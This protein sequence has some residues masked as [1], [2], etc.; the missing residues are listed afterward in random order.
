MRPSEPARLNL[1]LENAQLR[2]Q[3]AALTD[4]LLRLEARHRALMA[5]PSQI[6]WVTSPDGTL[7]ESPAWLAY[8]GLSLE[9]CRN[10]GWTLA[11]HPDDRDRV[12]QRWQHALGT[13]GWFGADF[14]LRRHDGTYR[15]FAARGCP[16]LDEAGD[17]LEWL[18]R[19]RDIE[20]ERRAAEALQQQATRIEAEVAER[21]H[22]LRKSE[23]MLAE[24]Q[25]LA[26][27]G[28]W[29]L[30]IATRQL[31]WSQQQFRN[32]G[33]EPT[34]STVDRALAV[35]RIDPRDVERH[36]AVVRQAIEQ[37]TAF[38]MD[39]RVVQPDG[40]VLNIHS[41]G[42]PVH[43][44]A[45][46]LI[47]FVGTSQDVTERSRLE[48]Q[49]RAQYEQLK[50][51]DCLKNNIVNSV[52]HELRT[53][54]TSIVGFAEFLED[55][56]GGPVTPEQREFIT[57]IQR[58]ARRLES[59]LNDLLD[60]ARM[61]AG[62]FS[63]RVAPSNLAERVREVIESLRPQAEEAR[64]TLVA[65]LPEDALELEM[66][67]QRIGQVLT[68]LL[69]NA[70]KFTPPGGQIRLHA[71]RGA[72]MIRCAIEDAGPGIAAEDIPRLFQRF[73]Q[74][75]AGVRMGKGAGLGLSI[76]KAL[77]EA[78]GGTIGLDS[79]PGAGSTFWFELPLQPPKQ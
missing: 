16:V 2:D 13:G 15:W 60:F 8:T 68:N 67:S 27:I 51:V 20:D 29:E 38:A 44:G 12:E 26:R 55:E 28:S 32:F 61:Q 37:G 76:S 9:A 4:R 10:G 77:V 66:D 52:T 73:S 23:G 75:E 70:I 54:L 7:R 19:I 17:V 79:V 22:A 64:L 74:L 40:R 6:T 31:S 59:L 47:K 46:R 24:S 62:T 63:L 3:V 48:E 1:D 56:I 58:G 30:D 35:A 49:L 71:N 11:L 41:I 42:R 53:P 72:E 57:Q 34:A 5:D 33:L 50:E 21:T 36:E 18:G 14:R 39:Y 43:D 45:G 65:C 78:H 69:A 25:R